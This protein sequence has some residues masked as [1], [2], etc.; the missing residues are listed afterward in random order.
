MIDST[1]GKQLFLNLKQ[2]FCI[3]SILFIFSN[4]AQSQIYYNSVELPESA[5]TDTISFRL[6]RS[7]IIG[8]EKT[9]DYIILR[10][11]HFEAADEVSLN[12]IFLAQKR[13]LS[14][15]LFNR[16]IFDLVGDEE[17]GII[18]IITVAERW[19]IFPLPVFYLNERSWRR[20]SY[21]GKLLYYNFS[22]RNIL[23]NLTSTFGYNPQL[24]FSYRNPWF[25]GKLKLLTN[26]SIYKGKVKSRN[27]QFQDVE[28]ERMGFDWLIGR[29]FGHFFYV[30]AQIGYMEIQHDEITL[31]PT[32]KD[33]LP[34]LYLSLQYDNRDLK[35]YPHR[36]YNVLLWG[37][38]VN[39]RDMI[40]YT[41]YGADL[42]RYI[43]VGNYA[44]LA[45]RSAVDLSQRTIP[46]YDRVFLGYMERIRG[47]FY[48][49]YEGENLVIGEAEFRFPISKIRYLDLSEFAPAGFEDYYRHLK[50]GLSAGIFFD[51]GAVWYQQEKLNKS[52][53]LYGYGFGL[54]IHLPYVE[55]LRF[56]VG[57]DKNFTPELIAEIGVAF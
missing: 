17:N 10:E 52:H 56:E 20:I 38:K 53:F 22:G 39:Y 24:K 8:N 15:F 25:G 19:Y 42:R 29:R 49:K 55:L 41:R 28:D 14:L 33:K 21:G 11:L 45:L 44:T 31:S 26:F 50:F 6:I 9:K 43:P 40:D 13:V 5:A 47:K 7:E 57:F 4:L 27:L 51:Y 34:S 3:V 35:E 1:M 18:L 48:Q 2:I 30:M 23:L 46:L 37:K 36:G 54:H 16:V 12:E 32:G